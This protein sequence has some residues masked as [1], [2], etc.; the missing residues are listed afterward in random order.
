M[1]SDARFKNKI[2]SLFVLDLKH[3]YCLLNYSVEFFFLKQ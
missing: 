3:E 2:N 1:F